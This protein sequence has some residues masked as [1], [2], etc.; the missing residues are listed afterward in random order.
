[1]TQAATEAAVPPATA[2]QAAALPRIVLE[3][4]EVKLGQDLL[5]LQ[6]PVTLLA[7]R[8]YLLWG[9]SGSGKSSFARALLGLGE[10]SQPRCE[11]T[12]Q[13][14]LHDALGLEHP[15]WDGAAYSPSAR[16]HIAFLP[17]AEKLGFIDGLPTAENL[18][19]FSRLGAREARMQA[20]L[21]AAR[22]HLMG[23]PA[24]LSHASGGERIRCSAVRALMPRQGGERPALL[25]ADE[26]TAALDLKAAEA[27]AAE[28]M[29]LARRRE[30]VVVVITHDPRA[31]VTEMPPEFDA[32]RARTVRILECALPQS[33]P[34]K[35]ERELGQLKLEPG[36]PVN[37][38]LARGQQ[39]LAGFLGLLGGFVLAPAAFV[40]GLARL[41]RPHFV[42]RQV[43][44]EALSPGTQLFAFL[45]SL[46]IAGTVAFFIFEQLPRPEL[47]E[48]LL[49]AEILEVTG[50]TLARV[51]LPLGAAAFVAGKLGA[52][53]AA[54]L[55]AGVRSGLLETLA[56]ARWPVES[57]GLVGAVLAQTLATAVATA[58]ALAGGIA[59]AALIYVAGHEGASLGLALQLMQDGLNRTPHWMQFLAAKVIASGFVGGSLAALFGLAPAT[60]ENDVAKAVHRTLLWGILGVIAVQCVFVIW[61]FAR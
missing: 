52:A 55:S 57:F 23:L 7:G 48:P 16:G 1:M 18:R 30:T 29:E 47:V 20:D 19:L 36:R 60:S 24:R 2:P 8:L 43:F 49:L 21:L 44:V 54:R 14:V 15:L 59:L 31:F 17:Q 32:A 26:P 42:A 61:E 5:R 41:R 11:V 28:L 38:W 6:A 35:L 9:P 12:G 25:L 45:G 10:L 4:L 46:L 56:L 40:W 33:G 22:F 50:H 39:A 37:P 53:Q 13:V 34:A 58:L 51:V 27:L 3:S